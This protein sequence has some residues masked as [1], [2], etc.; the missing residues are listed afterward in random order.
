MTDPTRLV[1]GVSGASGA[2]LAVRLLEVLAA[3]EGVETHLVISA[4]AR[5]TIPAETDYSVE[6]DEARATQS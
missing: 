4:A 5:L 3:S 6:Q 1:V 2:G